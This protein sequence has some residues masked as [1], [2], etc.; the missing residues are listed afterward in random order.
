MRYEVHTPCE[1]LRPYVRH[2]VISDTDEARQY[3][4]LPDTAPVIGFQYSGKLAHIQAGEAHPLSSAGITGLL[5]G[6]RLFENVPETRTVLVVFK[7]TG[8]AAFMRQPVHELYN[9]S[10]SLEHFF[11]RQEINDTEERLAEATSDWERII[12]VEKFL[13]GELLPFEP[14]PLVAAALSAIYHSGGAIRISKLAA[15]LHTSQS[16]LEKRFRRQVGS[17]PKKFAGIVRIRKLIAALDQGQGHL[18]GTDY[19]EVF[20]DQAH[21]IKDFKRFTSMTPEE[22]LKAK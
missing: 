18:D 9:M 12:I 3:S 13:I 1:R 2:L 6:Y 20:Y 14:D 5:N 7:E 11:S 15:E 4:I 8:L 21:F 22:F 19:L 16:P 10:L 17:S